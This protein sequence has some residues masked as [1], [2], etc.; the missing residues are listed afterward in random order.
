[1]SKPR[2]NP[3]GTVTVT[4]RGTTRE[5]LYQPHAPLVVLLAG[6]IR[7]FG[8]RFADNG[9]LRLHDQADT[10]I[11]LGSTAARA[12]VRPGAQ[13]TLRQPTPGA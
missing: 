3:V 6:A 8:M 2:R 1:M 4:Y 10:E 5:V 7:A 11:P 9:H 12:R 13:L